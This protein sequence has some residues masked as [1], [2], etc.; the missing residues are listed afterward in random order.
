MGGRSFRDLYDSKTDMISE[1]RRI[2]ESS[3]DVKELESA[4]HACV[5]EDGDEAFNEAFDRERRRLAGAAKYVFEEPDL[6]E[7]M[8]VGGQNIDL[9]MPGRVQ[10]ISTQSSVALRSRRAGAANGTARPSCATFEP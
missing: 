3:F 2:F 9:D 1:G 6:P 10:S 8:D 4:V 5:A 7:Y